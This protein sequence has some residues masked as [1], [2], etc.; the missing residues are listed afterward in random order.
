[1]RLLIFIFAFLALSSASAGEE[2]PT[3][4]SLDSCSDQLVLALA[5]D[6]QILALSQ[7]SRGAFSYFKERAN[8]F[9]QHHGTAEEILLL[10]PDVVISTGAGDPGLVSM[11]EGLGIKVVNTGLPQTIEEALED[12]SVV[13][14]VLNQAET[15]EVQRSETKVQLQILKA[16]DGFNLTTLYVSPSG[17]TTGSGTFLHQTMELAGLTNLL[18]EEGVVGW[19]SF[20]VEAFIQ[21]TPD[22]L[23][24]SFFDS[25]VGNAES[26]RFAEHPAM[27][28]AMDGVRVVNVPSRYLSCPAWYAVE[29]AA[30]IRE[31]LSRDPTP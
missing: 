31:E 12:L 11:L 3:V 27:Q 13:G 2:M 17:T 24:T 22:V 8:S 6:D 4:V 20:Q 18:A 23:I 25:R 28:A 10:H 7:D 16:K 9:P 29:G 26:W 1:M 21:L 19:S 5:G 15:A 30:L 14:A